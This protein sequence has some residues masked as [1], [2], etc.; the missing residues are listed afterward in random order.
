VSDGSYGEQEG[1]WVQY[2]EEYGDDAFR[3]YF[4]QQPSD[5][6]QQLLADPEIAEIYRRAGGDPD[7]A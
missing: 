2:A 6:R 4:E 5:C 7:S 3:Q 1:G